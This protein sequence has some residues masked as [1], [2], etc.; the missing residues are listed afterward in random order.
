MVRYPFFLCLYL[1]LTW[2]GALA[3][4]FDHL[5]VADNCH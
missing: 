4:G 1:R 5:Q 3:P 2:G